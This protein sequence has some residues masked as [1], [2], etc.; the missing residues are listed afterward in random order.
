MSWYSFIFSNEWKIRAQRHLLFWLLWWVYFTA[1]FYHYE[2]SGLQQSRF[3]P[4]NLPFIIKS[5]LLLA[6]HIC[7]C[8]Y[9]IYQIIPKY[10]S[11]RNYKAILLP[12][13]ILPVFILLASYYVYS[14]VVPFVN[15]LFDY[16]TTF[17]SKNIWWT[18]IL[19]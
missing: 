9:F 3:E 12:L 13:I 5:L 6:I 8:Y 7:A 15:A 10:L 14:T 16:K 2:Q 4:W 17:D 18:S 11:K 1:S 19:S